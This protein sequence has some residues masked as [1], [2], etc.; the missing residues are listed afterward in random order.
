VSQQNLFGHQQQEV[1]SNDFYTPA[2]IFDAMGLQFDLDV[3]SPPQGVPWIPTKAFYTQLDD[4]LTSPWN[5]R[6][7]MNPPF[8]KVT[9]W[10]E[11][12][13]DHGNGVALL[14]LAK[15]KF[16][17]LIMMHSQ[18]MVVLPAYMKFTSPFYSLGMIRFVC[19]L[20]AIGDDNVDAISKVGRMW[21]KTE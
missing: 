8:K 10:V 1:S 14:P 15:S 13:I 19:A 9:P 3:A 18:A 21:Q 11:K 7:W 5:G 2:W 4:G 16:T 12:F 20:F 17:D 6:V